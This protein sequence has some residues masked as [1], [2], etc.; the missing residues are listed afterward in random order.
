MKP[1][2]LASI[3]I[4][5]V[6]TPFLT[7]NACTADKVIKLVKPDTTGGM[8][9]MEALNK[10]QS[11]RKFSGK[12]L[13]DQE[14]SNLLWAADGINRS[15]SGKRTAPTAM[16]KQ[17]ISVYVAMKD[18]MYLYNA[19]KHQLELVVDK[20]LRSLTGKQKFVNDAPLNLVYVADMKKS[21]GDTDE[22]KLIYSGA[23]AAFI[24][25]NVYLYCAS[26]GLNTVIRAY[27]D[28][29]TLAKAM[30]LDSNKK[31]ILAQTVGYPA[32]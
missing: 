9:L 3:I 19:K 15:D 27:I 5:L 31:I 2:I 26:A 8:P 16:D 7:E 13:S 22:E 20:D 10:R 18:G 14:L 24:G 6:I 29:D 11:S 1:E 21:A 32:D 23:D 30:N 4:A 25:Q 12:D 17:E 28:K